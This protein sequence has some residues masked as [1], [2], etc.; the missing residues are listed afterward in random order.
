MTSSLLCLVSRVVLAKYET[1]D[2]GFQINSCDG[3]D[4]RGVAGLQ[5]GIKEY[6]G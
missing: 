4:R 5:I 2:L 6:R 1:D 3:I